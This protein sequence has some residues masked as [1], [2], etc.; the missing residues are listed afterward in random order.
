MRKNYYGL[1][2][3]EQKVWAAFDKRET[4]I[5]I[6]VLYMRVYGDPSS[7]MTSR[8]MQMRL[9]PVFRSIN[10]KLAKARASIT[11]QPGVIKRTYRITKLLLG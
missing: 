2:P 4:D 3:N 1:S 10:K 8:D 6:A 7:A 9:G 11:I 5:D